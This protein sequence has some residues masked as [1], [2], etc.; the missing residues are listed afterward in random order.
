MIIRTSLCA[1]AMVLALAACAVPKARIADDS[2][3]APTVVLVH[4]A[5]QDARAWDTVAPLLRKRGLRTVAVNLPGREGDGMALETATLDGYR[6]AVLKVIDAQNGPVV[7]VGHSFG[8]MTI[9][10]VAEA[11]PEKVKTLVYVAA[12]L[13]EAGAVDQSMAKLAERDQWNQFNKARQNFLIAPDYSSATVLVDDR[14]MLFCA[15][16]SPDAKQKTLMLMQRE[17][18]A[19]AATPVQVTAERYG[20]VPKIYIHTRHDNAVSYT[21]QQQMVARTAVL[22]TVTLDTGHSPF[23]EAPEALADAIA[24]AAEANPE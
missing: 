18:L 10:N 16:C 6:D 17:P 20:R 9:S 11:A 14:V 7:L 4:G 15:Q 19:P 23:L 2:A 21:L 13:P 12:Y 1:A 22:R 5:F 24:Q 3:I 8:G